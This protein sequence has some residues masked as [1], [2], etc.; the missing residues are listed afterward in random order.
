MDNVDL[1]VQIVDRDAYPMIT[2]VVR[3]F[4]ENYEEID[5]LL[6]IFNQESYQVLEEI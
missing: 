4:P 5:L 3:Q 2:R 1:V 6:D